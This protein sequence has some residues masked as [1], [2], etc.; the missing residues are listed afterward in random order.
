M[1]KKLNVI[2]APTTVGGNPSGLSKAFLK[3]GIRSNVVALSQTYLNY[4]ADRVVWEPGDSLLVREFKRVKAILTVLP[5][6]DVV[7]YNFGTTFATPYPADPGHSGLRSVFVRLHCLYLGIL[8]WLELNMLKILGIPA[9][10]IYQGDDARQGDYC[11]EYFEHSIAAHV[12]EG[13]YSEVSDEFKRR[14]IRRMAKYCQGIYSVNPDLLYVLP[15]NARFIPYA[16]VFADEIEPNYCQHESR[17]LRILHAPTSR[18]AKGTPLILEALDSLQKQGFEFELVLIEGMSNEQAQRE[19][20]SADVI[21]D[22]LYAGW[23][24]GL[25]VEVMAM[26]KPVLV[27]LREE[28]LDFI[29]VEMKHDLPFIQVTPDD[30]ELRLKYVIELPREDLLELGRQ[31]RTFVE[32]WHD[33]EVIASGLRS[34]YLSSLNI[35]N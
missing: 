24:G 1:K 14:S 30:V 32:K 15:A 8:Q 31:S 27:Y 7:Q 3:L 6:C 20:R 28:D 18:L 19:Y 9:F 22:Q 5:G 2:H 26:G 21:I 35:T 33:P 25:A 16:H 13:Y 4:H 34:D 17:P 10:V 12:G 11:L 23:Y 29:P